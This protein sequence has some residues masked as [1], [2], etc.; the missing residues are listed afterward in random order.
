MNKDE[1]SNSAKKMMS[2]GTIV[3][4]TGKRI[5][6]PSGMEKRYC[7]D[8]L[9]DKETCVHGKNCKFIHA[10]YPRGFTD[11]DKALMAKHVQDTAGLTFRDKNVS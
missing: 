10:Q 5:T 7:A 1:E 4:T 3:N 2:Y 9:D 11:K 8:F 6:F